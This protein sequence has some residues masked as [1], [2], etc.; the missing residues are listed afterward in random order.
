[1][2]HL[3]LHDVF[4]AFGL[5]LQQPFLKQVRRGGWCELKCEPVPGDKRR[6]PAS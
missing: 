2:L 6:L 4:E 3:V 1:M 5:Y